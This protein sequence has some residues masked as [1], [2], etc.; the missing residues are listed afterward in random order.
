MLGFEF[1]L[2]CTLRY[3]GGKVD[4]PDDPGGRTNM[5]ITQGV[6]D[7][8]R[9]RKHLPKKDVW[10]IDYAEV[11]EI[12]KRQYWDVV[13]GDKLPWPLSFCVF[14]MAVNSGPT[15]AVKLLQTTLRM[16]VAD[17]KMS[18]TVLGWLKPKQPGAI[19]K[20]FC[21]GR[22]AYYRGLVEAKPVL[23]KFLKGW[24]NRLNSVRKIS[25]V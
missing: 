19:A 5:G 3:E 14:D 15:K 18:D 6:Y 4:D 13:W 12:Y 10:T 22:E 9:S 24:L 11:K 20:K 17:G 23:A 7:S 21:D 1:A 2:K 16:P 8:Y 25:G